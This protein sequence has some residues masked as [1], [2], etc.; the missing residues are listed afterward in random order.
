[1]SEKLFLRYAQLSATN[2]KEL[3]AYDFVFECIPRGHEL[4][5]H[6]DAQ[7]SL[8][9]EEIKWESN[10]LFNLYALS[11]SFGNDRVCDIVMDELIRRYRKGENARREVDNRFAESSAA[12]IGKIQTSEDAIELDPK[13]VHHLF[14]YM[15]EIHPIRRFM[16]DLFAAKGVNLFLSEGS[17]PVLLY[18]K[19]ARQRIAF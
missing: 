8:K 12:R 11:S 6:P 3:P 5:L 1:V 19:D 7:H 15:V 4:G 2:W 10:D 17:G 13:A 16:R 14:K 18:C 9:Q